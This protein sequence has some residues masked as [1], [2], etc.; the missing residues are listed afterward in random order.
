MRRR[1]RTEV[2]VAVATALAFSAAPALGV[3]ERRVAGPDDPL[4]GSQWH[5]RA[6]GV[7]DAWR[8]TRG[9][10]ATVAV[11]DTGVAYEDAGRYRKAPDLTGTAFVPGWDFVDDDDAP[12]DEPL[13][14]RQ[15]HGTHM[16]GTIAQTTDNGIGGAGVAPGASVM[17]VR[18]LGADGTGKAEVITEGLRF[19]ADHGADVANLSLGGTEGTEALAEAVSYAIAKGVT[20]VVSA[21]DEGT[22]VIG[23]PAAYPGVIAV[24][25]VRLDRTR[26]GYS[27]HGPRLDLVAPGGDL[28]ADQDQDGLDDGIVQQTV[29]GEPSSFC[30]CFKNGTSSA[31][32]HVSGVAALLVASGRA[33]RPDDV[34][35]ALLSSAED[36]GPPGRD[37]EYGAGLV[38][39]ARALGIDDAANVSAPSSTP[40]P[41]FTTASTG[42]LR[43]SAQEVPGSPGAGRVWVPLVVAALVAAALVAAY[44]VIG[45]RGR[46]AARS[47][48]A[49]T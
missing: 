26:A 4:F 28:T 31:A 2:A 23:F 1:A 20:V 47:P 42:P 27:S 25:A 49:D 3:A 38:N 21:G 24:G 40:S 44:A 15:S 10:G 7:P 11:L 39:A 41:T 17:P 19:A 37:D 33:S 14:G 22:P 43:P 30:F 29:F 12:H 36:L 8:V 32:A 13:P 34:R 48:P 5:L 45:R 6:V 18:V 16:A 9:A 46:D 35:A